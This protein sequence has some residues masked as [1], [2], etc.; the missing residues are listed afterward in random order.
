MVVSHLLM[1][2]SC[3][4]LPEEKVEFD[5]Q[6]NRLKTQMTNKVNQF[7]L[8]TEL[9]SIQGEFSYHL[10]KYGYHSDKD[11][12]DIMPSARDA[13]SWDVQQMQYCVGRATAR[14]TNIQEGIDAAKTTEKLDP[15]PST[16]RQTSP[17]VNQQQPF[18][19]E[20]TQSIQM[21][22]EGQFGVTNITETPPPPPPPIISPP[23]L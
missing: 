12:G 9:Q 2:S 22:N 16:Q 4:L 17:P 23:I 11:Y 19:P 20:T 1:A 10:Q 13:C 6:V 8:D 5:G 21:M 14:I 18:T 15:E 7:P 3:A